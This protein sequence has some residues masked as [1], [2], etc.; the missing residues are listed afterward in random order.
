ME[1]KHKNR[2]A[3]AG[4][5]DQFS[6]TLYGVICLDCGE[7]IYTGKLHKNDTSK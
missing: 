6:W 2:Q 5:I 3:V 4:G 1:C 7:C